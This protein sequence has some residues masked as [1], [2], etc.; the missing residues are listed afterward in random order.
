[1]VDTEQRFTASQSLEHP[2]LTSSYLDT[3]KNLETAWIRKYLARRRWQR[4][5]NAIKAMN[6]MRN[7]AHMTTHHNVASLN[8]DEDVDIWLPHFQSH[9]EERWV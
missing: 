6:R 9:L 5:F 3:L 7:M 4:W 1:V 2:W 8:H